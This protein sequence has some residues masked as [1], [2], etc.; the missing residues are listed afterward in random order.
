MEYRDFKLYPGEQEDVPEE[1]LRTI[2]KIMEAY[3]IPEQFPYKERIDISLSKTVPKGTPVFNA[4][5]IWSKEFFKKPRFLENLPHQD[6]NSLTPEELV[7]V[8]VDFIDKWHGH[9]MTSFFGFEGK[10]LSLLVSLKSLEIWDNR[11]DVAKY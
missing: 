7:R 3:S 6:P 2:G 5:A 1:E 8:Y 4:Y 9:C 10:F 11:W